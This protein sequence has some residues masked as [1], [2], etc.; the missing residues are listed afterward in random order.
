MNFDHRISF[1]ISLSSQSFRFHKKRDTKIFSF[2]ISHR[3]LY[4]FLVQ[5]ILKYTGLLFGHPYL[6]KYVLRFERVQNKL[7][8]RVAFILEFDHPRHDYS[9]KQSVL[10]IPTLFSHHHR[11]IDADL[12]FISSLHFVKGLLFSS[13]LSRRRSL[14]PFQHLF[15]VQSYFSKDRRTAFHIPLFTPYSPV[16]RMIYN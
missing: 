8:S 16:S 12:H 9:P 5:P 6:E 14:S 1:M 7:L 3:R 10:N 4:F 13:R 2:T 15:R 11:T